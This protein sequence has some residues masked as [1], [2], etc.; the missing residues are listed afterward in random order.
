MRKR[1][2]SFVLLFIGLIFLVSCG[3][4]YDVIGNGKY[5]I[6]E[7]ELSNVSTLIIDNLRVVKDNQI[8]PVVVDIKNSNES[9]ETR[10]T[11]EAQETIHDNVKIEETVNVLSIVGE[12]GVNLYTDYIKIE[13]YGCAFN[14]ITCSFATIT[15]DL[16]GSNTIV[17]LKKASAMTIYQLKTKSFQITLDNYCSLDVRSMD[18][19]TFDAT[20]KDN[21]KVKINRISSKE[22]N[23]QSTHGTVKVDDLYTS[24]SSFEISNDSEIEVSGKSENNSITATTGAQ[25][26]GEEFKSDTI[27][28]VAAG[29]SYL[30]LYGINTI[31]VFDSG[32][33]E[34]K[35]FGPAIVTKTIFLSK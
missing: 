18:L 6:K 14:D 17:R 1:L 19:T 27:T 35:Y 31:F 11:I 5:I 4:D 33:K 34:I 26:L 28:V 9:N 3:N 15:S 30:E 10:M 7:Y 2:F 25:F 16:F 12:E 20:I 8:I 29:N 23:V 24:N 13:I 32:A 21:S 22:F